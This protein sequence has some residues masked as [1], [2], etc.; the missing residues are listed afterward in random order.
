MFILAVI[1]LILLKMYFIMLDIFFKLKE[2]CELCSLQQP[3]LFIAS[4]SRNSQHIQYIFLKQH[5]EDNLLKSGWFN[6]FGKLF[7]LYTIKELLLHQTSDNF[8]SS[9][10]RLVLTKFLRDE[11]FF[12]CLILFQWW[13]GLVG[14][15]RGRGLSTIFSFFSC[16]IFNIISIPGHNKKIQ[17]FGTSEKKNITKQMKNIAT[18][19][20][21]FIY[22]D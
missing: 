1:C 8:K 4:K 17:L 16:D 9:L 10:L 11:L 15:K 6:C 14:E 20:V 22:K 18:L 2:N 19:S 7:I 12:V 13:F 5:F 21:V 3:L